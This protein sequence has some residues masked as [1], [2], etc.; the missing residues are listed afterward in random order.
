VQVDPF[1][2]CMLVDDDQLPCPFAENVGVSQLPQHAQI[3]VPFHREQIP[4]AGRA[5]D[6]NRF[7]EPGGVLV[8]MVTYVM[9]PWM[10][11]IGSFGP[12]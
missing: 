9:W 8:M 5:L 3:R 12:I 6:G 1:M 11:L 10:E 4:I 7:N 2:S